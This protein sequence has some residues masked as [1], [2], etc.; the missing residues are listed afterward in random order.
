MNNGLVTSYPAILAIILKEIRLERN[1]H[2]AQLADYIGISPAG[3]AKVE[4][5]KSALTMP[6]FLKACS[7]LG[8][9]SSSIMATAERYAQHFFNSQWAVLTEPQ[10]FDDDH[11]LQRAADYYSKKKMNT[12]T[13]H[14][15]NQFNQF[16]SIIQT[17]VMKPNNTIELTP[18]FYVVLNGELS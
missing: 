7:V 12:P 13:I 6:T 5:G 15:Q 2:Q 3:W 14:Y 11:L 4:Q 16:V 8:I 17:P 1:M 9:A 18:V 10:K